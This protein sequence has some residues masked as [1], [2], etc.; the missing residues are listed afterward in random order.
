LWWTILQ[1]SVV[2]TSV[3]SISEGIIVLFILFHWVNF[4]AL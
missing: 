3:V 4:E 2:P 1:I